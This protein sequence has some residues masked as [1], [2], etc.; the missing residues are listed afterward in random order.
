MNEAYELLN[1]R[2]IRSTMRAALDSTPGQ[3]DAHRDRALQ[4]LE[5]AR[6]RA[7]TGRVSNEI[8]ALRMEIQGAPAESDESRDA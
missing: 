1:L 8:E 3:A 2:V 4:L 5:E 6:S 7:T